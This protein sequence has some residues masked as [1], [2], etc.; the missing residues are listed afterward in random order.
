MYTYVNKKKEKLRNKKK[1]IFQINERETFVR[2]TNLN[3]A[4]HCVRRNHLNGYGNII[5]VL[6]CI[7]Q[8]KIVV[9]YTLKYE[10][11]K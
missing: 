1:T 11:N 2:A 5:S 8:D 7:E 3:R 9:M 4:R 6:W 10:K